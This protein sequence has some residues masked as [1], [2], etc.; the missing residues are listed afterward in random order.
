MIPRMNTTGLSAVACGPELIVALDVAHTTDALKVVE[1]L[2]DEVDFYKVGLEL[3][4]A[5]GPEVVTL[6]RGSGKRVFLDLKLHDIPRT[7][8]RAVASCCDLGVELLTLHAGGGRDMIKAAA[9]ACRGSSGPIRTRVVAVTVLTSL[10][11]NDIAE[12]G[13][14]RPVRD[15]ALALGELAVACGADGL[16]CSVL[17]ASQF[18][19]RLGM[20]PILVT[21]GI[22]LSSGDAGDQKRVATPASAVRAGSSFLVVGRPILD[23]PAPAEA[24]RKIREEMAAAR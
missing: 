19:D 5:S 12:V 2:G 24:A 3:F 13:V 9:E 21:P 15:H 4:S 11:D 17:E 7:V 16:V 1:L 18:R 14:A 23:S 8:A 20:S 10:N 22:R 6:L